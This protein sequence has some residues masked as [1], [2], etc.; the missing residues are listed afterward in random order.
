MDRTYE[1]RIERLQP[2][3]GLIP[4]DAPSSNDRGSDTLDEVRYLEREGAVALDLSLLQEY[5]E[6]EQG[7]P[8]L[9]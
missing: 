5:E 9:A 4:T 6:S 3:R 7:A 8:D 2:H 1:S